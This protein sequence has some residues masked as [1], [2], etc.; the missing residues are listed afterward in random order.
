MTNK[1]KALM[2]FLK[3]FWNIAEDNLSNSTTLQG[4]GMEGADVED[5]LQEFKAYFGIKD[6]EILNSNYIE[7]YTVR[8]LNIFKGR[9]L[10]QKNTVRPITISMLLFWI[11]QNSNE[12]DT[13]LQT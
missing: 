6:K 3:Q 12:A 11:E 7:K 2:S 5:F 8:P 13:E 1:R 4:L 10:L 9:R